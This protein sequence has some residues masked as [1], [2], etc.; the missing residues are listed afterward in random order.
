MTKSQICKCGH[1]KANHGHGRKNGKQVSNA[2]KCM[3]IECDC[4]LFDFSFIKIVLNEPAPKPDSMLS[5]TYESIAEKKQKRKK[6]ELSMNKLDQ[7][8]HPF[9]G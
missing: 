9:K 2:G 3:Y 4:E 6:D 7:Q 5:C 1:S 8:G